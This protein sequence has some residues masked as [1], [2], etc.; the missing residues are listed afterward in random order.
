MKSIK[1]IS[2]PDWIF[3]EARK[4]VRLLNEGEHAQTLFVGGCVRNSLLGAAATD[5][6]LATQYTPDEVMKILSQANVKVIPTG[7]DHGTVTAVENGISMEVTTLRKDVKTDGRHAVVEF[8]DDWHADASRRDFTMNALYMDLKGNVFDPTGQGLDDLNQRHIRFVGDAIK[9]IQEDYLRILRFFR[10]HAQYGDANINPDILQICAAHNDGIKQLS[11]ERITQEF[12]K[13]L[14]TAQ[15]DKVLGVMFQ[16]N[17]LKEI[18]GKNYN[19][20]YL[21]TLIQLQDIHKDIIESFSIILARYFIVS[22]AKAKFHDDF[23][24]FSKAQANFIIRLEVI[25]NEA[26]FLDEKTIKKTM[27]KQGRELTF[28]G[29]LLL[30][31]QNKIAEDEAITTLIKTWPIPE[32]PIT[33]ET[34]LKEGY[35]T[36]P[37]LGQELERRKEEWLETVI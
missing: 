13:I 7:I 25:A 27:V 4:I 31:A 5:I 15:A 17:I 28:Q 3:E 24:N 18:R 10:F 36:G 8:S 6:D 16:A 37:E 19:A 14:K 21:K 9:R 34:L 11:R 29:Y 22:G 35:P 33:G 20:E 32:C 12:F 2:L 30:C 23:L 1:T 26:F